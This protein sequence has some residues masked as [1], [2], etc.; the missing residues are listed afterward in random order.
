[1]FFSALYGCPCSGPYVYILYYIKLFCVNKSLQVFQLNEK[2]KFI[3]LKIPGKIPPVLT[4]IFYTVF[5]ALHNN[6]YLLSEY[7]KY[8][9]Q[10]VEHFC[11]GVLFFCII[12]QSLFNFELKINKFPLKSFLVRPEKS[13]SFSIRYCKMMYL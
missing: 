8:K 13:F 1:M 12:L 11:V 10:K 7:S 4:N 5:K 9:S 6:N 3:F 2:V